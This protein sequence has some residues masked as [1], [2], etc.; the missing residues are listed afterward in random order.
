MYRAVNPSEKYLWKFLDLFK[1]ISF[2]KTRE[3]FFSR[4]D[5]FE[6]DLELCSE[7]LAFEISMDLR[8]AEFLKSQRNPEIEDAAYEDR[9]KAFIKKLNDIKDLQNRFCACCFYASDTESIAMWKLYASIQGVAIRFKST[10]LFNNLLEEFNK[11][12]EDK[13]ELSASYMKYQNLYSNS[14]YDENGEIKKLDQSFY[15]FNK[16]ESFRFE[17]E[18]RFVILGIPFVEIKDQVSIE[19]TLPDSDFEFIVSPNTEDWKIELLNTLIEENGFSN[20]IQ[21]SSIIT[22]DIVLKHKIKYFEDLIGRTQ[23]PD[24]TSAKFI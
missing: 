10:S 14:C 13:Y 4:L 1:F 3:V 2:P 9:G 21:K 23:R 8:T 6:D 17:N 11:T 12:L 22:K 7:N 18:Y 5:T 24:R 15:A 16:D 20:K 19:L